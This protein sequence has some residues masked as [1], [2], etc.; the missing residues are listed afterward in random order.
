MTISTV[1]AHFA[2]GFS[3][4][5]KE[6]LLAILP[7]KYADRVRSATGFFVPRRDIFISPGI[8]PWAD[9]LPDPSHVHRSIRVKGEPG[10]YPNSWGGW[11]G[12]ITQQYIDADDCSG[13]YGRLKYAI[14]GDDPAHPS[15]SIAATSVDFLP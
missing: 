13:T 6:E 5:E 4:D 14:K 7:P 8:P 10:G 12:V 2:M 11:T 15:W 3:S 1:T 9:S